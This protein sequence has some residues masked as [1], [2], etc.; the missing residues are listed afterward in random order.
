M[1]TEHTYSTRDLCLAAI[2]KMSGV[3]LVRWDSFNRVGGDKRLVFYFE[4][5]EQTTK[6]VNE[7]FMD[8]DH[9]FKK[10]Y[11]ELRELKN[12]IYNIA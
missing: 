12:I 3:K 10:F 8:Q 9:P 11:G 2:L 6:I 1:N 5:D 4:S 7:Y